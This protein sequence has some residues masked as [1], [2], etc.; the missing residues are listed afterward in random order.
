MTYKGLGTIGIKVKQVKK[1]LFLS[2]FDGSRM[3]AAGKG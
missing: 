3:E 2:I 1:Y